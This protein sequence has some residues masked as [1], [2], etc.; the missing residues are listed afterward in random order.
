MVGKASNKVLLHKLNLKFTKV[1]ALHFINALCAHLQNYQLTHFA[2][3][4]WGQN[5]HSLKDKYTGKRCFII[6][7]GPSLRP[8]DLD[9]LVNEYT[10]AFNRIYYIFDQTP[11]RPTFYC[12]QDAKIARASA[13]KIQKEIST[14]YVFAPINLK[15]YENVD[16][17]SDYFFSPKQAGE[18]V[19]EFSEDIPSRIGVGNTVAYTAMQLAVYMGFREIYL[20]GVDHSFHTYQDQSGNIITDSTAKDYFCAEYNQDKDRLFIPKLDLSTLSYLAAQEYAQ[21]HPVK[22][23]NATR[24]GK[25][26]VFP[27]VDFDSL[28]TE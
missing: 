27:R 3:T 7:N 5:L 14:S 17:N 21:T 13:E 18:E 20:I 9:K 2:S 1:I 19:P 16:I 10:F 24:G 26:E 12:T 4:R 11:W 22:I 6:G 15:W 25:L 28:F 8:E 23:Y